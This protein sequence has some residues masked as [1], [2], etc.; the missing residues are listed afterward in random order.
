MRRKRVGNGSNIEKSHRVLVALS[1][2]VCSPFRPKAK[3][4]QLLASLPLPRPHDARG[5][6]IAT[7]SRAGPRKGAW[8]F[9]SAM[10]QS[11]WARCSSS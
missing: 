2:A 11:A 6:A 7:P 10:C 3:A 9:T 5:L 1:L 4:L 8:E